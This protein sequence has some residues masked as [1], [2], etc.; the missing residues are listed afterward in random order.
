MSKEARGPPVVHES[1]RDGESSVFA[2]RPE[3][4][5]HTDML[6]TEL[7]FPVEIDLHG[8]LEA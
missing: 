1:W 6:V 8:L 7:P 4:P 5:T 3:L 2:P